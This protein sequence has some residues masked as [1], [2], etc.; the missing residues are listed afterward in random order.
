MQRAS[1]W[2]S[3]LLCL[4]LMVLACLAAGDAQ[5][6]RRKKKRKVVRR[7]IVHI[8]APSIRKKSSRRKSSGR[9]RSG[10]SIGHSAAGQSHKIKAIP[11][12]QFMP[13]KVPSIVSEFADSLNDAETNVVEVEEQLKMDCTWV[14]VTEYYN[15]WDSRRV[16]PYGTKTTTFSD[17]VALT[18]YDTTMGAGYSPPLSRSTHPTSHFGHRGG[19]FHYGTDLELDVG[20]TIRAVFDGIV[21]ITSFDGRGYG[22]YVLVRHYNGLETLYGHMSSILTEVGQFVKAGQV[23]GL[24]GS[25]GRSS[26]PH[27]HFEIRYQGNAINTEE[28]FDYKTNT[29]LSDQFVLSPAKFQ[30]VTKAARKVFYHRVRPGDTMYSVAS[31]YGLTIG[32]LARLNGL[33]TN[34]RLRSGKR[35]RVK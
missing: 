28:F 27:L 26:G 24:G 34:A 35:L 4:V 31:K 5:A 17:T 2:A 3:R 7:D 14:K 8:K 19:R 16:N 21:R 32:E 11:Y 6:Q 12:R 33:R 15:L 9:R 18:L 13:E 1:R 23:I 29:L 25:T 30:Y 20:D 22:Y 10:L